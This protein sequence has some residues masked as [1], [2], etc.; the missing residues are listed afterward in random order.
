MPKICSSL[1]GSLQR[2]NNLIQY[3]SVLGAYPYSMSV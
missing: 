1:L 2:V 3:T